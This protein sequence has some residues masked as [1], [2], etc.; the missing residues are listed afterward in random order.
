MNRR[1]DETHAGMN[2][3]FDETQA[4][5][6]TLIEDVRDDVRIVAEGHVALEKRVSA[7]AKRGR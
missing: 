6:K 7:L 5:L 2:R 4:Q 1:F 3:R